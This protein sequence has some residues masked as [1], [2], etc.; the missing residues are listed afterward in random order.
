VAQGEG[1]LLPLRADHPANA[2]QRQGGAGQ[3]FGG[4]KIIIGGSALNRS[5][6]E[7]AWPGASS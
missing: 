1:H 3:D 4:W 2:A 7:A 5:L 6:Y